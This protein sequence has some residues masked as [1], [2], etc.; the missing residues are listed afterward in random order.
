MFGFFDFLIIICGAAIITDFIIKKQKIQ[1]EM[2]K[3]Q[4]E[5]EKVKHQNYLI[6]TEKLRIDLER[7][8]LEDKMNK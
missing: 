4:I 2:L 3:D 1:A 6:E 7:L 8:Q 5:L